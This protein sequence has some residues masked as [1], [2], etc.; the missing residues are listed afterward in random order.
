MP[1]PTKHRGEAT[2]SALSKGLLSEKEIDICAPPVLELALKL[3]EYVIEGEEVCDVTA[4]RIA[5]VR[6]AAIEAIVLL[7]NDRKVL[8]IRR[9]QLKKIAVIGT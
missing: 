4:E 8:P 1:G 3:Q 6:K 5:T 9:E 7:K 2:L